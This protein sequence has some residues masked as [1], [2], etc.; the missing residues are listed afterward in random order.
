MRP[1]GRLKMK[2]LAAFTE[3][4]E[5]AHE[6]EVG[7]HVLRLQSG[8]LESIGAMTEKLDLAHLAISDRVQ[9]EG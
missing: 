7:G 9:P 2:N 1:L 4:G 3:R 5:R 6:V 8:G